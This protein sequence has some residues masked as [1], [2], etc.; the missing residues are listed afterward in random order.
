MQV[1]GEGLPIEAKQVTDD[2]IQHGIARDYSESGRSSKQQGCSL[3]SISCLCVKCFHFRAAQA[4]C[5]KVGVP[6]VADAGQLLFVMAGAQKDVDRVVPFT[7]G[8]MGRAYLHVSQDDLGKA[9]KLKIIGNVCSE[10]IP[11]S[12]A[13]LTD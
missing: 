3:R 11:R 2:R 9:S 1:G 12:L 10:R 5:G 7:T 6:A 13:I 4:D 8:V